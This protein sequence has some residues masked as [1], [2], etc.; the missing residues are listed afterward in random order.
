MRRNARLK[1]SQKIKFAN[2]IDSNDFK[3]NLNEIMLNNQKIA[4]LKAI[5]SDL[6]KD[7]VRKSLRIK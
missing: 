3:N 4:K 1:D 7:F 5:V 2:N 6:D